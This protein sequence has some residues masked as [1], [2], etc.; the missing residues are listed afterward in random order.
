MTLLIMLLMNILVWGDEL[1]PAGRGFE[2]LTA[3]A[4]Q[5]RLG[6]AGAVTS[7]PAL[8]AWLPKDRRF[9]SQNALIYY[10]LRS[11]EDLKV[12]IDIVPLYAV[13][14][15]GDGS[16]GFAYG[17][18]TDST[19]GVVNTVSGVTRSSTTF[20]NKS[21]SGVAGFGKKISPSSAL[22][23]SIFLKRES[24]VNHLIY[25]TEE[26]GSEFLAAGKGTETSWSSGLSFGYAWAIRNWAFGLS[27]KINLLKFGAEERSEITQYF[28]DDGTIRNTVTHTVGDITIAPVHSAGVQHKLGSQ[29]IFFDV[30]WVPAHRDPL[31]DSFLRDGF[32]FRL[33]HEVPLPKEAYRLY[34]GII[35]APQRNLTNGDDEK[36]AGQLSVGLSKKNLH[37]YSLFGLRWQR[38]LEVPGNEVL[39]LILGT[40]F[41][42]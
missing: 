42:Y 29:R 18:T 28:E 34:S 37:S 35:F 20:E 31:Q 40:Q 23:A 7:N 17:L 1:D 25:Q 41:T 30:N 16:F 2:I 10:N 9:I 26:S 8:L 13:T 12:D 27:S 6:S 39:A 38:Q 4:G 11:A 15:E 32:Q 21:I 36:A 24:S 33:G 14:S 19:R 5:A 3:G 22:G